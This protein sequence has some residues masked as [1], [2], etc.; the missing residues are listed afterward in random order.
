MFEGMTLG[1]RLGIGFGIVIVSLLIIVVLSFV[2][3]SGIVSDS[4]ELIY[5]NKL[6]GDFAAHEVDHLNWANRVNSLLTDEAVTTLDVETDHTQCKF[7]QWLFSDERKIAEARIPELVPVLEEIQKRHELLHDSASEISE[8]YAQAHGEL[9]VE[10]A[11][12]LSEHV[13]WVAIVSQ[14]LAEE[15]AGLYSYQMTTRNAVDQAMSIVEACA[16]DESLGDVPARQEQAKKMIKAVRYGETN[17]DYIWI[18]NL[19]ARMVMHPIK[20]QLDG[21]DLS[22]SVDPTGKKFF[23][24][25]AKVCKSDG[26]GFVTYQWALP[27][28]GDLCPKISYVKLYEPWGWILGTGVYLDHTN[29]K[30]LKRADDFAKH[31]KFS[32]GVQTDST[33]C[34]FGKFL[35]DPAVDALCRTFP[36]FKTAID[37]C[38]GP[39]EKLHNSAV[40]IEEL[41]TAVKTDQAGKVFSSE[42]Q[43][44]LVEVKKHLKEAIAAETQVHEESQIANHIY[45]EKTV[46]TL[47]AIQGNF[48]EMHDIVRSNLMTEEQMLSGAQ[49]VKTIVSLVGVVGVILASVMAYI[50]ARAL[51]LVLSK[52]IDSLND[53]SS[54]VAS[55]SVQVSSASQSLAEG[56]T[57]QAAGLEETSSS[58]EEM[59]AMTKQN[60]DNA[61]QASVLA[62]DSQKSAQTGADA[63]GRMTQAIDDIQKSS[64]E[65]AKIIKVIDEIAFQTNLLALNAAV[66]AARA[67]EAGKGFAVVA[68]EVRNLAMRSAEAAKNTSSMIE[69]SV[70]NSRHGVEISTEVSKVLDEIVGS[71]QKTSDLV[72]EISAASAEQ[73]QGIDQVNTAVSQMDKVTQQNAANAEESAS[74]AGELSSQADSMS[75]IVAELAT[76]VGGTATQGSTKAPSGRRASTP[77]RLGDQAFHQIARSKPKKSEPK[78]VAV[79]EIPFDEDDFGDF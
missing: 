36:E 25:M 73:A 20:P 41:V 11:H 19:Q 50:I 45:A 52:I 60:A 16:T 7:G 74:A 27:G 54:Q 59:S 47:K 23:V 72:G 69:E 53:G 61:Q 10:L 42:T 31:N 66:E 51:I 70:K 64:D 28:T 26:E 77:A 76:L 67:G 43:K 30:L 57:E 79:S 3:V 33:Q 6:T 29:Q 37:Q 65:T 44:Y 38:R 12:R 4:K 49:H 56:A 17:S 8:H 39:H 18:N 78:T 75:R 71:V 5:G 48:G 22:E 35:H 24:E 68:E 9:A 2:G 14:G 13:E 15:F 55:A 21:T 34:A 40:K 1:K 63:M 62:S 46:P 32:L 58:L